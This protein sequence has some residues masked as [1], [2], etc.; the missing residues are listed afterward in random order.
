[1]RFFALSMFWYFCTLV[2]MGNVSELSQNYALRTGYCSVTGGI[3]FARSQEE[4]RVISP[5]PVVK[6]AENWKPHFLTS[7]VPRFMIVAQEAGMPGTLVLCDDQDKVYKNYP[8]VRTFLDALGSRVVAFDGPNTY[9]EASIEDAVVAVV[10]T[11]RYEKYPLELYV[12]K[13]FSKNACVF[14]EVVRDPICSL[15]IF[16]QDPKKHG[17]WIALLKENLDIK[18]FQFDKELKTHTR[19]V[20]LTILE[21]SLATNFSLSAKDMPS[22][23]SFITKTTLFLLHK[24]GAYVVGIPAGTGSALLYPQK[25]IDDS[26]AQCITHGYV[27]PVHGRLATLYAYDPERAQ[28]KKMVCD[29]SSSDKIYGARTTNR[30]KS[31]E[32]WHDN[33]H[34]YTVQPVDKGVALVETLPA[35]FYFLN[36]LT[37]AF[38]KILPG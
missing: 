38:S 11:H 37:G 30:K 23:L 15:A 8:H 10:C 14:Q 3:I 2:S 1:M 20:P 22:H 7:K 31:C 19:D 29:L 34:D 28:V 6:C 21:G 4:S 17:S 18:L 16:R 13:P 36:Y 27:D 26:G 33:G 12:T 25:F 5:S 32:A 9:H 24:G 35:D